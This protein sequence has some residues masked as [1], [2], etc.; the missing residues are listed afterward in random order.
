MSNELIV[1]VDGLQP[2]ERWPIPEDRLDALAEFL[3]SAM[4]QKR[5]ERN[6]EAHAI[7][8]TSAAFAADCG[9]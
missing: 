8:S 1:S 7:P 5:K 3:I 9:N 6:I 2:G 4:I